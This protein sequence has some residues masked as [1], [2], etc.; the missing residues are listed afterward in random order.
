MDQSPPH[1]YL[2]RIIGVSLD[3][4]NEP[5]ITE[6]APFGTVP[7]AF[8]KIGAVPWLH[9]I[10]ILQQICVG[11][12]TCSRW[13]FERR[14]YPAQRP[15]LPLRPRRGRGHHFNQARRRRCR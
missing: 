14:P 6:L 5:L 9:K 7:E 8:R 1:Q 13:Y 3:T 2:L 15:R 4:V 10:V 11:M 12:D